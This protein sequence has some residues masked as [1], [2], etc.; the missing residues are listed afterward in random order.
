MAVSNGWQRS[1]E[2]PSQSIE[3]ITTLREEKKMRNGALVAT[4]CDR[5]AIFQAAY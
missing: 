3:T 4:S 5:Q 2:G 1:K